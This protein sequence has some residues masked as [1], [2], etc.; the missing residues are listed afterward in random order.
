M[1][2]SADLSNMRDKNSQRVRLR[3]DRASWPHLGESINHSLVAN[4]IQLASYATVE[5][6]KEL[7]LNPSP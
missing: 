2:C 3:F 1:R 5:T 6:L 7:E 4:A